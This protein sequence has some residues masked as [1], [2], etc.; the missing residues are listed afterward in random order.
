[1]TVIRQQIRLPVSMRRFESFV[2]LLLWTGAAGLAAGAAQSPEDSF[3]ESAGL[4]D[5]QSVTYQ[6]EDGT[7]ISADEFLRSKGGN[8]SIMKKRSDDGTRSA[9]VRI[10]PLAEKA[11]RIETP[12]LSIRVGEPMPDAALADLRGVVRDL[13]ASGT[14]PLLLSFFFAECAPCIQEIPELNAFARAHESIDV[15]AIT[16]DPAADANAFVS[17]YGLSWPVVADAHAYID[18]L[19]V[20]VYPTILLVAPDGRLIATRSGEAKLE[21]WVRSSSSLLRQP[22]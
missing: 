5:Y 20:R 11:A 8:F 3:K 1:M 21:E 16:F 14:K 19:G 7:P 17:K 10:T 12:P 22:P 6:A 2:A 4:S 13:N 18:K 15:V 9:I